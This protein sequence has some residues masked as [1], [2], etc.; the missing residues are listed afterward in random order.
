MPF[1]SFLP[2]YC[3]H[4]CRFPCQAILCCIKYPP[5][6][7]MPCATESK[8]IYSLVTHSLPCQVRSCYTRPSTRKTQIAPLRYLPD[9][10]YLRLVPH[11]IPYLPTRCHPSTPSVKTGIPTS[12]NPIVS[13]HYHQGPSQA[14]VGALRGCSACKAHLRRVI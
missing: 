1:P 4:A 7:Q 13:A 14:I 2:C 9:V 11:A 5:W 8:V 3:L 10:T 6:N 12:K